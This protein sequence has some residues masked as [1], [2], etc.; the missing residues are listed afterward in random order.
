LA[1]TVNRTRVAALLRELL[2]EV[3]GGDGRV[4]NY[5]PSGPVS[6]EALRAMRR[7]AAKKGIPL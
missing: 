7:T 2:A 6:E 3:E 5:R 4:H 1:L